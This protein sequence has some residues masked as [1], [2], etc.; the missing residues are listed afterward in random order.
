MSVIYR[1]KFQSQKIELKI[2]EYFYYLYF[3]L[4]DKRIELSSCIKF[5]PKLETAL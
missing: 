5:F 3:F 1:L 2:V 4:Y